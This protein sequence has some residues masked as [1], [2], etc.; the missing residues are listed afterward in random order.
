MLSP[1]LS[2]LICP[3][4]VSPTRLL[5]AGDGKHKLEAAASATSAL[6]SIVPGTDIAKSHAEDTLSRCLQAH[7]AL[8]ER[9]RTLSFMVEENPK[10]I[11]NGAS[12]ASRVK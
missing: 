2:I 10:Y 8:V 7:A 9:G 5:K 6:E 1:K 11:T 4:I 3:L 12:V